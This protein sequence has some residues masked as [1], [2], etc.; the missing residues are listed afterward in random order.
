MAATVGAPAQPTAR[1][2]VAYRHIYRRGAPAR[3]DFKPLK[4]EG[5]EITGTELLARSPSGVHALAVAFPD[6]RAT[7]LASMT[8]L[9]SS[10]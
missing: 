4:L 3:R 9:S 8:P 6:G 7:I 1:I 2:G 5:E 10:P